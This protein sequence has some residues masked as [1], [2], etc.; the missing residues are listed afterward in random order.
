MSGRLTRQVFAG[1]PNYESTAKG[2]A[3]EVALILELA[4]PVCADDGEFIDGTAM[5]DRV[6]VSSHSPEVLERLRHSVRR[7]VTVHG[8]AFGAVTAHHHAP[9]VLF[10]E[11]VTVR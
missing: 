8:G 6:Q 2:D 7:T 5:F 1:P 10:A 3:P 4:S 9:L 11:D